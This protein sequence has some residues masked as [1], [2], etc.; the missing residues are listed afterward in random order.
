MKLSVEEM[1]LG[2]PPGGA[3]I[4]GK[5]EGIPLEVG[6]GAAFEVVSWMMLVPTAMLV[7]LSKPIGFC[8]LTGVGL[9][10]TTGIVGM[11]IVAESVTAKLVVGTNDVGASEMVAFPE[12]GGTTV[13]LLGATGEGVEIGA[14]E[15]GTLIDP[16]A[17]GVTTGPDDTPVPEPEGRTPDGVSLAAG[18]VI[19]T[20]TDSDGVALAT[21]G[22]IADGATLGVS[23]G[24]NGV[25]PADSEGDGTAPDGVGTIPDGVGTTPE[26]VGTIPEKSDTMLDAML[27]AGGRGI[28][29]VAVGKS[30]T[31]LDTMLGTTDPG[32]SG[33]AEDKR[34][35]TSDTS[36]ETRG[37]RIP[38]GV[39]AGVGVTGAVGPAEPEGKIPVTSET[40]DDKIEGRSSGPELGNT[41][42]EVGIAPELKSGLAG[43]GDAA[44]VPSAV[45]MPTT[46]PPEDCETK[47]G[48]SLDGDAGPG[49]GSTTMLGKTPVEPT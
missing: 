29:A 26:G 36:E 31:K 25:I 34:L 8:E 35:D 10:V 3:I 49:V 18:G 42:S 47:S 19:P 22:V 45:V 44:P 24:S 6:L 27:L 23:L 16:T 11:G 28:G 40:R 1:S 14:S 46:I 2:T 13:A 43:V 7:A 12:L 37:G 5:D 39:G 20:L 9:L 15:A 48:C 21:G 38:G 30:E 17:D 32:R 33:T 4:L 41:A